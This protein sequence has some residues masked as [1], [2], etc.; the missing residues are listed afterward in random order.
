M[1][2]RVTHERVAFPVFTPWIL[3]GGYSD[4]LPAIRGTAYRPAGFLGSNTNNTWQGTQPGDARVDITI[5]GAD[6]VRGQHSPPLSNAK[7]GSG[8]GMRVIPR[9]GLDGY[10]GSFKIYGK[11]LTNTE[12]KKNFDSQKGFFTNILIQS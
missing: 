6:Y 4:N 11:P 5:G 7:G 12:A 8:G 10:L 9:S 1:A 2:E 3:G